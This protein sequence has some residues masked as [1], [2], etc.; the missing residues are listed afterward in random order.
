MERDNI[1]SIVEQDKCCGCSACIQICSWK[2]LS[3]GEDSY[4]FVIPELDFEKCV[5]CG[6]C[7]QVCPSVTRNKK[8]VRKAYGAMAVNEEMRKKGSSGG[9]FGVLADYVLRKDG[10]V[11]GCTMDKKFQVRHVRITDSSELPRI[12]KSKYV[13]SNMR[14]IYL[15]IK[16]DLQ[17]GKKVM[18]A[19]TPCQVSA[20]DNFIVEKENLITV[21]VVCHGIPSQRFFDS[22]LADL[23]K[24]IG[25]ITSYTFRAK[26]SADNGMNWFF[27]YVS[28]KKRKRVFRNWPEDTFNYLYMKSYIY[29]ES[30]YQCNYAEESRAGDITLCDYWSWERYHREFSQ[31]NT[32]SAILVNSSKGEYLI[33]AVRE[34][35][36]RVP[37]KME[38]IKRHNSCLIR[39]SERPK[40]RDT[41]FEFWKENG[42]EE[43][44]REYR[45]RN[46]NAIRKYALMRKIPQRLMNVFVFLRL[47]IK[48]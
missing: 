15:Q 14:D 17:E 34:K 21:D 22:Y 18:F 39:P 43:L 7:I 27:S 42:F 13:Q 20:V 10:V 35:L 48:G 32:V 41:I 24:K 25:E 1:S 4:G 44:D 2:A 28:K 38:N 23:S 33:E 11:Y 6:A 16:S 30:C 8:E 3:Y 40:E 5:M 45:K 9:I 12:M 26:R 29:R 46:K 31:G 47:K 36:Q 37:A 19:G